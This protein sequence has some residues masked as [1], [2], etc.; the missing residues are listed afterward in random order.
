MNRYGTLVFTNGC[1][2]ILH[3]G[4]VDLLQ[5]ARSYGDRLVVGLNSDSSIRQLKGSERPFLPETDRQRMLEALRCVDEVIIF[6]DLTPLRLIEELRPDVLI[7]GGDWARDKIV[8]AE[9]VLAHGGQV[10]SL[11]LLPG[12]STTAI[13]QR[14]QQQAFSG[15]WLRAS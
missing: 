3:P 14:I 12:Y 5:Q 10:L 2:D 1:F 13:A 11:P 15:R 7:K 6:D 9:C 8:G 4:H